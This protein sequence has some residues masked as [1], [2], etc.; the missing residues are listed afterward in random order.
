MKFKWLTK[1]SKNYFTLARDIFKKNDD[2]FNFIMT[3]L[4]KAQFY[5]SIAQYSSIFQTTVPIGEF[6]NEENLLFKVGFYN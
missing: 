6:K 1:K 4:N 3:S 2:K 5:R